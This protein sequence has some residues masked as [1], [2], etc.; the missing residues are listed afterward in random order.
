MV[1]ISCC[2]ILEFAHRRGINVSLISDQKIPH[3][4]TPDQPT[5]PQGRDTEQRQI[6]HKLQ[7]EIFN[8]LANLCS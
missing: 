2:Q 1:N 4:R 6:Q 5:S 3:L 7:H 8:I